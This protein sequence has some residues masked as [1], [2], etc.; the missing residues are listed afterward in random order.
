MKY[1]EFVDVYN[2]SFYVDTETGVGFDKVLEKI[3]PLICKMASGTYISGYSFSDI[4]QELTVLAIEGIKAF[5]PNK[6]VKL[7][8]FL[9]I[10][11]RNKLIS[12]LRSENRMSNDAFG[13]A[14][15]LGANPSE[16]SKETSGGAVNKIKRVREEIRF[17]Q[18]SASLS[19]DGNVLFENTVGD[20]E[21]IYQSVKTD[22]E[23]I[24]FEVSL[25]KLSK[26]LDRKTSRIIELVYFEDYSIKDAAE[27]V[28][29]T[30][31]A[32]SM[33][34]KS[35]ARKKSFKDIF[36]RVE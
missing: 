20:E 36:D 23:T 28:G 10:H 1:K 25:K 17:S 7:S 35:L 26:K 31:W 5:N 33:R 12:K 6:G 21:G 11:L 24:N 9:H 34:L 22:Y 14:N 18:C 29:L 13:L 8:T 32:A 2:E 16:E 19:D 4:K 15:K 27:K 30:G 3:E